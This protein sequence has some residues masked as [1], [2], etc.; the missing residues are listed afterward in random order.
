MSHWPDFLPPPLFL[1]WETHTDTGYDVKKLGQT[2]YLADARYFE[3]V[4]SVVDPVANTAELIWDVDIPD[5]MNELRTHDRTCV[6]H[7]TFFDGKIAKLK[8]GKRFAAYAC[9]MAMGRALLRHHTPGFSLAAMYKSVFGR[10]IE[11]GAVD[12]VKGFRE[13]P[14]EMRKMFGGYCLE[15]SVAMSHL[16]YVLCKKFPDNQ[17]WHMDWCLRNHIEPALVVGIDACKDFLVEYER[18]SEMLYSQFGRTQEDFSSAKKFAHVLAFDGGMFDSVNQ[19]GN[20]DGTP[21]PTTINA[22]QVERH[23]FSKKDEGFI[24]A[25]L[26]SEDATIR[27]LGKLRLRAASSSEPAQS[28]NLQAVH[29]HTGGDLS[30]ALNF[31]GCATHRVSGNGDTCGINGLAIKRGS[32]M[33]NALKAPRGYEILSLDMSA[34]ELGICRYMAQDTNSIKALSRKDGDLYVDFAKVVYKDPSLTKNDKDERDVGKVSELQCQYNSGAATLRS[35]LLANGA[36]LSIREAQR[37]V[38]AFRHKMHQPLYDYWQLFGRYIRNMARSGDPFEVANAPF[39][40]IEAGGIRLPT[41][42]KLHF[43]D[44][45]QRQGDWTY[46]KTLGKGF[47]RDKLY[48]GKAMQ[49][50][51][52]ALANCIIQEKKRAVARHTGLR[53]VHEVYD[54]LS[55]RVPKG[56]TQKSIDEITEIAVAPV[57][58]WPELPL[59]CE[60]G[61]PAPSWGE[62][63]KSIKVWGPQFDD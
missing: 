24:K 19:V 59:S 25:V 1:D 34:F 22:K 33:R 61:T 46:R 11:K 3:Q 6:A 12:D 8:H 62:C 13:I 40:Q 29:A 27:E 48:G 41:G 28:R 57:S 39:L 14:D 10:E 55:V 5:Y 35:Q 15:D 7:N 9:T 23:A 47:T 16:F 38:Q 2:A 51:C 31:S 26:E 53:I 37:I 30:M 42:L 56:F 45:Q 21:I 63:D 52:Q 60:Y 4:V 54:D 32:L 44:L 36:P 20:F 49:Y 17:W 50:C 43:P 58:F 18:E